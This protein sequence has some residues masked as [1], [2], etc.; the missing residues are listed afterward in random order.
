MRSDQRQG[1][2]QP[3]DRLEHRHPPPCTSL[4]PHNPWTWM[5]GAEPRAGCAD[6]RGVRQ[7]LTAGLPSPSKRWEYTLLRANFT[8]RCDVSSAPSPCPT[9][10]SPGLPPP[11]SMSPKAPRGCPVRNAVHI[12]DCPPLR[13]PLQTCP[14]DEG[15]CAG[16][17][18]STGRGAP[19]WALGPHSA[20]HTAW[21][22]DLG[23]TL[24]SI[25]CSPL[26]VK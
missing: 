3:E 15:G 8:P 14:G 23:R 19:A 4:P 10:A 17:G 11:C 24:L 21:L 20:P 13:C 16:G 26:S 9:A 7:V 25:R 12:H 5:Q 2:S 18:K 22:R 6:F 1:A